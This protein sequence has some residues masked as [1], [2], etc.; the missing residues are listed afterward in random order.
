MRRLPVESDVRPRG[1][2]HMCEAKTP[3][4]ARENILEIN[5]A[6]ESYQRGDMSADEAGA[7]IYER[8]FGERPISRPQQQ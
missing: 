6:V 1:G 4:Q 8:L 5:Q 2:M 3:R 7:V